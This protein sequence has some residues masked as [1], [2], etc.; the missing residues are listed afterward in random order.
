VATALRRPQD[1]PVWIEGL[2]SRLRP[3]IK[4]DILAAFVL[5]SY[6][7]ED[8]HASKIRILKSIFRM[9]FKPGNAQIK[10]GRSPFPQPRPSGGKKK[11]ELGAFQRFAP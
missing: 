7:W 10:R 5:L 1:F 9:K 2:F 11:A 6:P 3:K 4:I 8:F